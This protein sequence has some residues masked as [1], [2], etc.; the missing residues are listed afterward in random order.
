L[1]D[2]IIKLVFCQKPAPDEYYKYFKEYTQLSNKFERIDHITYHTV[3]DSTLHYQQ[4]ID[5]VARNID[6][7]VFTN[8]FSP[9]YLALDTYRDFM[10]NGYYQ[11]RYGLE[12]K[13][14]PLNIDKNHYRI[15]AVSIIDHAYQDSIKYI[16]L[17]SQ[18]HDALEFSR[19]WDELK[20]YENTFP[21][22]IA[23]LPDEDKKGALKALFN[24]KES[25]LVITQVGKAAPEF[26]AQDSLGKA[27]NLTDY[28]GKVVLLD[29]WASWC[30]PCRYQTPYLEKIVEKYKADDRMVFMSVAVLDE[31]DKWKTALAHDKPTWLQLFDN[32]NV[33]P[34]SYAS[35]SIP[36]FI[37]ISKQG[38][39]V[40][41]DT[42]M[43][44]DSDL[45]VKLLD[46][47]LSK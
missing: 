27:Y 14:N 15:D 30:G 17:Y 45:L 31:R 32:N 22:Y 10:L 9:K 16:A 1:C 7:G 29:L 3:V 42:P 41:F 6:T 39:I 28:K 26:T 12:F 5:Y 44:S 43:P 38:N 47:E 11:Y 35:H 34:T 23:E 13:Y 2:S 8:M 19:S 40:S 20:M 21:R 18:M 33:I 24:T 46:A 25:E 4:A 37:L 36:K